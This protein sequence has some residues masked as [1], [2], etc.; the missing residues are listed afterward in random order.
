MADGVAVNADLVADCRFHDSAPSTVRLSDA[1]Q[2]YTATG[3]M[4]TGANALNRRIARIGP[5][6]LKAVCSPMTRCG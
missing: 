4:A 5:F 2:P 1:D 3:A 6:A